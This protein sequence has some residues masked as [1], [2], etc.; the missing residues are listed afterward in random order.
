[1]SF[2]GTPVEIAPDGTA[3]LVVFL[4]H[5]CPHCQAEVPRLVDW[6]A[7]GGVP[8]GVEVVAVATA[9]SPSRDNY[10]PSAWLEREGWPSPVL[11]DS[12][13][14]DAATAYGLPSFPYFVALDA[15]GNV[16]ARASG[17]LTTAQLDALVRTA[18]G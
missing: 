6:M 8:E 4:A 16:T 12:A 1:V 7:G 14:Y 10:P 15:D 13:T 5:W 17:E 9:T 18:T 11:V 3:K 2:D